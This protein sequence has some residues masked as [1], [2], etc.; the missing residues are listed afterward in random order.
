MKVTL[1]KSFNNAYNNAIAAA[2]TCYSPKI[3]TE[4]IV[5]KNPS[6]RDTV[7]DSTFEAEH[8]TV[9]QHAHWQFAIEGVSRQCIWSFLHNQKFY[10]SEQQSQR[11][12]KMKR[13]NVYIPL[14]TGDEVNI[15][16]V[17]LLNELFKN[18]DDLNKSLYPIARDKYFSIFPSR[19]KQEDK[20]KGT[21]E[22]KCIEAARSILPIGMLSNLYHTVNTVTLHRLRLEAP[23]S[24][25]PD[26]SL[27][28]VR[29]MFAEVEKVCPGVFRYKYEDKGPQYRSI[30]Y[31]DALSK[32]FQPSSKLNYAT[33]Q[34][35]DTLISLIRD[36]AYECDS[37]TDKEMLYHVI[38][39][40]NLTDTAGQLKNL[41]SYQFKKNTT[42]Y[43]DSQEQRHRE[44][45]QVRFNI[46][47]DA[48]YNP[49][50]IITE[51]DVTMDIFE[52]SIHKIRNFIDIAN[53][54]SSH[55]LHLTQYVLPNAVEVKS[56]TNGTLFGYLHKWK[57]RLCLN[58]QEEAF[59]IARMEVEE[60]SK[61]H[62]TLAEY[63]GAPCHYRN[64]EGIRPKCP[65]GERY[66]GVPVWKY[67]VSEI[68]RIL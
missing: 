43:T 37:M 40:K 1:V 68:K 16:Y 53:N 34:Y 22:K 38:N 51:S 5:E 50:S 21:I 48:R 35:E 15:S 7:A 56:I 8:F 46:A 44:I 29:L 32:S 54:E 39:S 47:R 42:H 67:P 2:Y 61:V 10:N 62:P 55:N 66:C 25:T 26:E 52:S 6:R 14:F 18:Y 33:P 4:E 19:R 59:N 36:A 27:E 23:T 60:V 13:Q 20:Y 49:P 17:E 45:S 31:S 65:E 64:G 41:I 30:D 9:Y 57:M 63:I 28:L 24:N 3:V 58:A 12:V 11:Y